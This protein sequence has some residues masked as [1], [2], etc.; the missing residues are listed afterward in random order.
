MGLISTVLRYLPVY[1]DWDRHL[2]PSFGFPPFISDFF[3]F[4]YGLIVIPRSVIH[5]F[6]ALSISLRF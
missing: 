4:A 3:P 1:E 5:D 6:P 2:D